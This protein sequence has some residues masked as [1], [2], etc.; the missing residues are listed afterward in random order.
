[1]EMCAI[2]AIEYFEGY[3][4]P[5]SGPVFST[6]LCTKNSLIYRFKLALRSLN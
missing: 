3:Y 2:K 5:P 4:Y 6:K 1:M